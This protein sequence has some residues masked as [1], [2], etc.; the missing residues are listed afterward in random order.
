M[1]EDRLHK[2]IHYYTLHS[3]I[4]GWTDEYGQKKGWKGEQKTGSQKD[5]HA[6]RLWN[7]LPRPRS[8]RD[9]ETMRN[10]S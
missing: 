4:Y 7:M 6:N 5:G 9:G 2:W 10:P 1:I 8:L 3:C